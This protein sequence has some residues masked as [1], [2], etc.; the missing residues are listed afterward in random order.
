MV[1][2]TSKDFHSPVYAKHSNL[3]EFSRDCFIAGLALGSSCWIANLASNL[4]TEWLLVA[5]K[6]SAT[7]KSIDPDDRSN[8]SL[9][10]LSS[11]NL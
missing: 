9:A 4:G 11:I 6:F 2:K 10:S 3:G 7:G 5:G 8:G 1:S